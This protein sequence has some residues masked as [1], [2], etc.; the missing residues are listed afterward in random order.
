MK[1]I[2]LNEMIKQG[3]IV[4]PLYLIQNMKALNINMNEFVFIMYLA[5]FGVKSLFNPHKA[6]EDFK[7]ELVEI[8]SLVSSLS[9]KKLLTVTV[10][11]NENSVREEFID[12]D[13]FYNKFSNLVITNINEE[14][15]SNVNI[16]EAVEKEFGRTLSP[17]EYEIIKAWIDSDTSDELI[18]EAL[19]EATMSGVSNLRYIDKI[20]YEWGKKGFKNKND[21]VSYR[22][23]FKQEK[24]NDVEVF[25]YDWYEDEE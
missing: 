8:M 20:L 3:N 23:K 1:S 10:E 16:F 17:I 18:L 14:P 9:E 15:K 13:N 21:I 24:K 11:K 7:L 6:S 25:E 5:N 19:K 22:N 12:L 2:K 4:L